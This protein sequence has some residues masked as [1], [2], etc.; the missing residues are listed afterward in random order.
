MIF[1]W[2]T[3]AL[4]RRVGVVAEICGG[5]NEVQPHRLVQ[6]RAIPHIYWIPFGPGKIAGYQAE[7][8]RCKQVLAT[9]PERYQARLDKEI[10]IEKLIELTLPGVY[11][12][13][14]EEK[15]RQERAQRGDLDPEERLQVMQEALYP[16]VVAV[17]TR[18]KSGA[19]DARTALVFLATLVLP[20]FLI[21]PGTTAGGWVGDLLG[22]AGVA[23]FVIGLAATVH[24][25]RSNVT[26][27]I[28]RTQGEAIRS[29]LREFHPSPTDIADIAAGLRDAG[30]AFGHKLDVAWCTDLFHSAAAVSGRPIR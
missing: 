18:K 19:I 12:E 2:G 5:C 11:A 17:E 28:R 20:W 27:W 30:T 6:I 25:A 24:A 29:A 8:M 3:H 16:V 1:V 7:C 14:E 23:G 15:D 21:I 4:H 26:R 10:P 22:W 9:Q 13:L